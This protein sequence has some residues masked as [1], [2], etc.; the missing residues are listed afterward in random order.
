MDEQ[1]VETGIGE[2][3]TGVFDPSQALRPEQFFA[4]VELPGR[5]STQR[6][7]P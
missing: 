7:G 1:P 5:W 2:L 3:E 6:P 4:A